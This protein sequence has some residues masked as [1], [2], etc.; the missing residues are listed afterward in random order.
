VRHNSFNIFRW[1]SV[2][3]FSLFSENFSFDTDLTQ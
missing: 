2:F 3:D 1:L